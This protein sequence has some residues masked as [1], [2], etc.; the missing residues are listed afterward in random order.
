[1]LAFESTT[2]WKST[3]ADQ[4]PNESTTDREARERL[5]AA[6]LGFRERA[7]T[8]AGEISHDLKTLTVH[9]I[10][11]IDALWEMA[12]LIVG[13]NYPFCPT[14]AFIL[15]GAF[16]L[17]DLGHSLAALPMGLDGLKREDVWRDALVR[18]LSAHLKRHP[19]KDEINDPPAEIERAATED[20]LR[21]LHAKVATTLC[22][23]AFEFHGTSYYLIDDPELRTNYGHLIGQIACSHWWPI[24]QLPKK[25]NGS[26]GGFPGFPGKWTIDPVKLGCVLRVADACQIDKRRAPNFLRAIRKP[27]GVAANHWEFQNHIQQPYVENNRIVFTSATPFPMSSANAWWLGYDMIEMADRELRDADSMLAELG[28][29]RFEVNAVAGTSSPRQMSRRIATDGWVPVDTRLR[30]TDVGSIVRRLGGAGLYGN[31]PVIPLR[32]LIQNARDAVIAR[33]LI[34]DRDEC[35]GEI[36]IRIGYDSD[37]HWIDVTDTGIGMSEEVLTGPFLDFGTSYWGSSLVT[38]EHP[39]LLAK[40]FEPTGRFGIGFYSVF[41]WGEHVKVITRGPEVGRDETLVLEFADGLRQRPLLRKAFGDERRHDPGTSV[42]VFFDSP[43]SQQGNLLGCGSFGMTPHDRISRP[44]G[45]TLF[46]L[47]SWLCP[48]LDVTLS[49]EEKLN[50]AQVV[51]ASDWKTISNDELM[52]R[53]YQFQPNSKDLFESP[54]FSA[55][56]QNIRPILDLEGNI[57][58]RA[59]IIPPQLMMDPALVRT[60]PIGGAPEYFTIGSVITDGHLRSTS[61]IVTSGILIGRAEHAARNWSGPILDTGVEWAQWAT[62]QAGL[63]R[64][65]ATTRY[66]QA[67][68]AQLVARLAGCTGDLLIAA[69]N[70][71]YLS[72][73]QIARRNDWPSEV[74]IYQEHWGVSGWEEMVPISGSIGVFLGRMRHLWY[75]D[76]SDGQ[77]SDP[78]CRAK[79]PVWDRYW[80]SLLGVTV[81][82]LAKSWGVP[83]QNVLEASLFSTPKHPIMRPACQTRA[84]RTIEVEVDVIRKP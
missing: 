35:W 52:R 65:V 54:E 19:R 22:D 67:Q 36:L 25:L 2:L 74:V 64:S 7:T 3:L 39:G 10:T 78:L 11:H 33:R 20:S 45:W 6:F 8:L 69:I 58:G 84:G 41:M 55:V 60:F 63:V 16:L 21:A 80:M 34:E 47:C 59:C 15:G 38:S 62:E 57:Y 26:I 28:L 70:N 24:S 50:R 73:N 4:G 56:V 23:R 49:V 37:R 14:E 18:K 75:G 29:P 83:L 17:H 76:R 30:I 79:H 43:P 53:L 42:R 1:L 68:C 12:S 61:D 32:E 46:E 77:M 81:E 66:E 5:R 82:A 9:D 71:A 48:A 31:N 72:F 40:G 27:S 13:A 51:S 44:D